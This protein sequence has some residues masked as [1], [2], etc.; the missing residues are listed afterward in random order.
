MSFFVKPV[1]FWLI[2][3]K[4]LTRAQSVGR[5]RDVVAQGCG[6]QEYQLLDRF[7]FEVRIN[8]AVDKM[9]LAQSRKCV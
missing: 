4:D 3:I 9:I 5:G 1:T 7:S 6:F 2:F 8:G